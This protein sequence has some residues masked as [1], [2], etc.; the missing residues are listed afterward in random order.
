ML[1]ASSNVVYLL[2]PPTPGKAA[3]VRGPPLPVSR[4]V[5]AAA[6]GVDQPVDQPSDS[7]A[8][9][10]CHRHSG[11]HQDAGHQRFCLRDLRA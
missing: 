6:V 3:R 10:R 5:K 2:I 8:R 11:H 9:R 1:G 4:V 7:N